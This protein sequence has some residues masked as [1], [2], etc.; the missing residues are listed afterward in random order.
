MYNI[1]EKLPCCGVAVLCHVLDREF[2]DV[3]TEVKSVFSKP[4]EWYGGMTIPELLLTL[5]DNGYDI[6]EYDYEG[7]LEEYISNHNET[8]I[9]NVPHHFQL[10]KDGL[11]HDQHGSY[12][13][14]NSL[15]KD[16]KITKIIKFF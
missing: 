8:V 3:F 6:E 16:K 15:W 4:Q 10:Y 9:I 7:S 12:E 11:L 1:P 2:F 5:I 13:V 14:E